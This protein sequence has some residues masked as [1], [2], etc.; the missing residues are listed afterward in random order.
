VESEAKEQM[1]SSADIDALANLVTTSGGRFYTLNQWNLLRDEIPQEQ[2]VVIR[3]L[4]RQ[5]LWNANWLVF[6]FVLLITAEWGLRR[7]WYN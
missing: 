7:R 2:R 6:L 5:L 1:D 3:E 4:N